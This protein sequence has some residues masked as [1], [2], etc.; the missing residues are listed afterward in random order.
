MARVKVCVCE[1]CVCGRELVCIRGQTRLDNEW[2]KHLLGVDEWG[3]FALIQHVD[4]V[5]K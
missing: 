3:L 5:G 1:M 2:L 4:T